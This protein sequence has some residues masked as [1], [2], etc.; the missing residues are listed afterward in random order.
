VPEEL[1]DNELILRIR[2]G[3]E[4]AFRMLVNRWRD[5]LVTFCSRWLGNRV[6]GE[7][8]AQEVCVILYEKLHLFR[9]ESLFSTWIYQIAVNRCRNR[10]GSWWNRLTRNGKRVSSVDRETSE[11]TVVDHESSPEQS[12]QKSQA[13][14]ILLAAV[15]NLP[16]QFR[17]VIILRDLEDRSYDEISRITG[18]SEGTVKSRINRG[19]A[20]LQETLAEVR[21]EF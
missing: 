1:N 6:D 12:A 10:H 9:G 14:A 5:R 11:I 15:A 8:V 4:R 13:Q 16:V 17:E 2:D 19:R 20:M 18:S 21:D 7:E 3:D